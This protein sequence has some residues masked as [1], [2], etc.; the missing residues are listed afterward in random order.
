V[1]TA[2]DLVTRSM[3][4]AG[5]IGKGETPADD[6]A[7]DG[8]TALNAMLDSWQI[9]RLFVYQTRTESFTW[10]A[11][12]QTRTVGAAGNFVTDNPTR[13]AN[14]CSFTVNGI[15]YPV[16]L[17]DVDA[18]TN[19]PDKST[20]SSFPWWLY[21]EYG[22]ALATINAYPIPN[23]NITFNLRTWHPLQAFAT[24][25]T[26]LALPAGNERA[27]AFSLAEEFGGPEFGVEVPA[28]VRR[29]ALAS[30]RALRK[31][32]SPSPIMVTE[33]GYLSRRYTAYIYGDWP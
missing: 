10:T 7:A 3:R 5:V 2:L 23:A 30:R 11:L 14:D 15:D 31:V 21:V 32:N 29:I 26:D 18:W 24:L 19:I 16:Q 20:Q 13:I 6:E 1:T 17:I 12:S 9:Q 22:A 4:L 25:A 28:D 27:I 8:L 33:A